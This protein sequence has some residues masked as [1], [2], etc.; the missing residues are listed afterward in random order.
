MK[1]TNAVEISN[2]RRTVRPLRPR[3]GWNAVSPAGLR[4]DC[5]HKVWRFSASSPQWRVPGTRSFRNVWSAV[6]LQGKSWWWRKSAS[7]YPACLWRFV[8]WP[9][10][11]TRCTCPFNPSAV[12]GPIRKTSF[13]CAFF[14]VFHL[15]LSGA[16]L[17]GRNWCWSLRLA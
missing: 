1:G 13:S 6:R 15:H 9:W 14:T 12:S 3:K 8:S 2:E 16:D 4:L 17:V 11:D 5:S 10:W 7:M